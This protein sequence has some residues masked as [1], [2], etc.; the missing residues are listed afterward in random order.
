MSLS[1]LLQKNRPERMR[2]AG[3]RCFIV[4]NGP[5][6][7]EVDIRPLKDEITI[8]VNSFYHHVDAATV[9]PP[10]WV[11]AD[12]VYWLEAPKHLLPLLEAIE[13][14]AICTKLFM[15]TTAASA[16][17]G[18]KYGLTLDPYFYHMDPSTPPPVS[19]NFCEPVPPYAQNVVAVALMLALHLGCS[20]IYLVGCDHDWWRWT[21]ES[22][23][24][25]MYE[26]G[27]TNPKDARMT[28]QEAFTFDELMQT[29]VVQRSQYQTLKQIA[30]GNGIQIINVTPG[31]A[32]DVFPRASFEE[33]FVGSGIPLDQDTLLR[34]VLPVGSFVQT[35]TNLIETGDFQGALAVSVLGQTLASFSFEEGQALLQLKA[36]SLERLGL[37]NHAH[38][39]SQELSRRVAVSQGTSV[40]SDLRRMQAAWLN[41]K[42]ED[43]FAA[44]MF[45]E[46]LMSFIAAQ[47]LDPSAWRTHNNLGVL[48]WSLGEARRACDCLE[49][50]LELDPSSR[51]AVLNAGDIFQGLGDTVR[52]EE[53]YQAYLRI[54]PQDEDVIEALA[55][56][57]RSPGEQKS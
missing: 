26:N 32:L 22:Y 36:L 3:K 43:Q 16:M 21:A 46:S 33:L 31:S 49:T 54:H 55:M 15:P 57:S 56:L 50:A 19:L 1:S 6:L 34:A 53:I 47:E 52:A 51:D 48:W 45:S 28:M 41:Q 5:S 7:R 27:Y 44:G 40:N 42:G 4:A 37:T 38:I 17:M 39:V 12:P 10:Y 29:V 2:H 20:P 35:A 18:L 13:Q 8:A 9:A 14:Q 11:I 25:A 24:D 30:F 23:G